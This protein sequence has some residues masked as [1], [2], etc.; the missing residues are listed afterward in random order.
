M[1]SRKTTLPK[2]LVLTAVALL[3]GWAQPALSACKPFHIAGTYMMIGGIAWEDMYLFDA[4]VGIIRCK[5][6]VFANGTI[7]GPQSYCRIR[8]A[9]GAQA[10][11]IPGGSLSVNKSCGIDGNISVT[12][13]GNSATFD[14]MSGQMS[15]NRQVIS[16]VG[17][18]GD[19]EGT[20]FFDATLI[21]R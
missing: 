6:R 13:N 2:I 15:Q 3:F 7:S 18:V 10:L 17:Y 16:A 19:D 1:N 14:I 4:D 11:N 20:S 12:L 21:R 9:Q 8:N 5:I